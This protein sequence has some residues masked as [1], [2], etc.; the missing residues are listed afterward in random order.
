MQRLKIILPILLIFS[1]VMSGTVFANTE[2][3][4]IEADSPPYL[5]YLPI[6]FKLSQHHLQPHQR[7]TAHPGMSHQPV[8]WVMACI[9]K[10]YR[11]QPSPNH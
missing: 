3:P 4:Q 6:V 2:D 1:F 10:G 11:L 8:F 7:I 5:S 9:T